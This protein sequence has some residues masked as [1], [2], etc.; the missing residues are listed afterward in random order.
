MNNRIIKN[1]PAGSLP[2]VKGP[3]MNDRDMLNDILATEKYL[4]DNF[5]IMQRE[6]SHTQLS[7]DVNVILNES[8]QCARELFNK[9]FEKG[10]YKLNAAEANEV[11]Q[12]QQQFRNY[13]SQFPY[14]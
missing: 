13:Q 7:N 10:W 14:K 3:G 2:K 11:M 12:S 4:T 1:Q 8:H 6:A 9:M 5:N